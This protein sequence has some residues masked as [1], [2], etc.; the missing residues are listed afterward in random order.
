M[1]YIFGFCENETANILA[2]EHCDE[3]TQGLFLI[4][5]NSQYPY[6]RGRDENEIRASSIDESEFEMIARNLERACSNL[7]S[8]DDVEVYQFLNC[9][10]FVRNVLSVN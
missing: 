6:A 4:R 1:H 8:D 10:R 5:T 9:E 3:V 7:S 2:G